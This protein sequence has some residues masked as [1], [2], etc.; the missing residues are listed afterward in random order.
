M[1]IFYYELTP[2]D[3][4]KWLEEPVFRSGRRWR[5]AQF[6]KAMGKA[7]EAGF[8]AVK[9]VAPDGEVLEFFM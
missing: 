3:F 5:D 7:R 6:P 8:D 9:S 1:D 2:K 4:K